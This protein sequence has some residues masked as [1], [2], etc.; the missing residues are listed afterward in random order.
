MEAALDAFKPHFLINCA[1]YTAVDQAETNADVC[2]RVNAEGPNVLAKACA[3][4]NVYLIHV[5]TDYVFNGQ[6]SVPQPWQETDTPDPQTVYGRTKL[7][8]ERAVAAAGGHY[9]VLRTAW[10]YGATGKNFPK[11]MLRLALA[12]PARTIRVVND[13]HGC[14]TSAYELSRQ[15]KA[16][17]DAPERPVGIFHAVA[18]E[19]T[20]WYGFA[21]AF[22]RLMNVPY[23]LEPCSTAEYPTP[24]MR[25]A[26]SIL[27]NQALE[28]RGLCVMNN[29]EDALAQFVHQNHDALLAECR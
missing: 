21:D 17:V 26:N 24:A 11:T 22:L 12:N 25:P 8:G 18:R 10:L 14:P 6:R 9:A 3:I 20:T 4:R 1:A 29:W 7:A 5:S 27:E 23:S 13:Q 15:I 16:L 28:A 19:H 2:A